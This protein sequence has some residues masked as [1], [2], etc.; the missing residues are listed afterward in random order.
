MIPK[1]LKY[2]G[3]TTSKKAIKLFRSNHSNFE[4][5]LFDPRFGFRGDVRVGMGLFDSPPMG[6]Y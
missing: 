5:G 6:S 4:A 2:S 1:T 3:N